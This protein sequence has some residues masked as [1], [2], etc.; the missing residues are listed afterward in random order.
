[1]A[2]TWHL[3]P[4]PMPSPPLRRTMRFSG[5]RNSPNRWRRPGDVEQTGRPQHPRSPRRAVSHRHTGARFV[6]YSPAACG[7][8]LWQAHARCEGAPR[9]THIP[10]KPIRGRSQRSPCRNHTAFGE[11]C[12]GISLREGGFDITPSPEGVYHRP[13]I[14]DEPGVNYSGRETEQ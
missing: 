2:A 8:H 9:R 11:R 13:S 3:S 14:P 10:L 7:L 4:N 6:F 12:Q 5:A 1:M